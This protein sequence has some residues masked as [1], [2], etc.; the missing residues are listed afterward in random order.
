M[1]AR[2]QKSDF[3]GQKSE[4]ARGCFIETVCLRNL[5]AVKVI[6]NLLNPAPTGFVQIFATII[7]FYPHL[8]SDF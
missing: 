8:N 6:K 4:F 7:N 1:P 5:S 2:G 3:R